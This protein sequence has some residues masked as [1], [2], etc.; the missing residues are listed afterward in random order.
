MERRIGQEIETK[1]SPN[2]QYAIGFVGTLDDNRLEKMEHGRKYG[3]RCKRKFV[4]TVI[5]LRCR[6][7]CVGQVFMHAERLYVLTIDVT[8][9]MIECTFYCGTVDRIA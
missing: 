8:K 1:M 6:S 9:I 2:G 7:A 3:T 5:P 4:I